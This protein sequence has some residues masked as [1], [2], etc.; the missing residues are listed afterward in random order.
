[1]RIV[2]PI[3]EQANAAFPNLAVDLADQRQRLI[4]SRRLGRYGVTLLRTPATS[5]EL[6]GRL[7]ARLGLGG[8]LKLIWQIAGRTRYEGSGRSF[9]IVPGDLVLTAMGDDY[10]LDM[11]DGHEALVLLFDP[12]D[13]PKWSNLAA[14]ALA[15]PIGGRAGISVTAAGARTLLSAPEDHTGELAARS[16]VDLALVSTRP[17][18][19]GGVNSRSPLM[20]RAT[21]HVLRNLANAAYWPNQLARDMG[22]SRRTLYTRLTA[23]GSTPAILIARTRLDR[24]RQDILQQRGRSLLDIALANGFRDGASLSRAFRAA[25]GHPPSRFRREN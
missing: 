8:H 17:C 15:R 14:D 16:L 6:S 10:R 12:A 13:D 4:V 5:V 9:D 23:A 20:A 1:M 3:I 18:D 21:L 7:A 2:A 19:C 11:L 22:M 25:Y 24:A